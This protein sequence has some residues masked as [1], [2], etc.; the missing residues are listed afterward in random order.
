VT[1]SKESLAYLKE[2]LKNA[3][4]MLLTGAG[5]SADAKN[6]LGKAIPLGKGLA[7]NIWE[8][9]FPGEPY[10]DSSSLPDLFQHALARH[11]ERLKELLLKTFTVRPE[12][13]PDYYAT[14]YSM[15]W[16]RMY[17]LNVD[18]LESAA[19]ARFA[20]PRPPYTISGVVSSK[21]APSSRRDVLEVVHLNGTLEDIPDRVTFSTS[22]YG[23]RVG[24]QDP[25]FHKLV[26]DLAGHPFVFV[27]T[28]LDE[29]VL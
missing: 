8:I 24:A 6:L 9:C 2:Q 23:R 21:S 29:A 16:L 17:T 25:A 19:A 27:G 20:L 15:P 3:R 5:F 1:I 13:L 10:E 26:G 11:R 18:D 22:Q 28:P 12:S 14:W 7:Q 4:P